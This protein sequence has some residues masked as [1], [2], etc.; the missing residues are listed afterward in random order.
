[1]G[2]AFETPLA[3]VLL[4]IALGLV[5]A[6]HLA[7]RRRLGVGR[8][9]AALLV[10]I[11][12]LTL[13]AFALAG[14]QL[15]L[16]VD[17]LATVFVVDL[18]DSVGT[19]GRDDALAFLRESL[20]AMPEGDQAGI[21]AFGKDALVERLPSDVR[22]LSR[23]ESTP[24][25][26]R[27]TSAPRCGSRRLS[28]PTMRRSGSS[29]SRTAT[30]RPARGSRRP[31]SRRRGDPH[32]DARR[33]GWPAAT[34]CSSSGCRPRRRRGS[35]RSSSWSP[36]SARPSRSRPRFACSS[37]APRPATER[38]TL[39]AGR[40]ARHVPVHARRS[41]ASTPSGLRRG[42][43]RHVRPERP[44][45]CREHD[46]QGRA[47]GSSWRP[48]T[49]TVGAALV[50]ALKTQGQQVDSARAGARPRGPR[51]VSPPTTRIVLVDVPRLRLSDRQLAATAGV[52]AR[53]GTRTGHGRR[54]AQLWRGWLHQ[55]AARGDAAGRHGSPRP[56]EAAR[57]RP[58]GGHRQVGVDG[59]L[60]L[61]LVQ[62]GRRQ[63]HLR[64]PQDGHR[65]GGDPAR[66]RPR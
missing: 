32:R 39:E 54:P 55:D 33:S 6:L 42:G 22:E 13:L 62:P 44:S 49:S 41:P 37:M 51:A 8:R 40:D 1:M 9:R 21:V 23:L 61:Q 65:Q 31:P 36:R 7:S 50:E 3:L 59:R 60:P 47:A 11:T 4:P 38:V 29:S 19:S 16:P 25:A 48:A 56:R 20:E 28:S 24:C 45:R 63:H 14:F 52:R 57:R 26:P 30:T 2:V 66:R 15:V 12:V 64:G 35:A 10:R 46:R 27:P 18:S 17:R 43:P 53:P 5:V 34:R 58:G